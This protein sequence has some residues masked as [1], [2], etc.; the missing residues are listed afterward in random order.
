MEKGSDPLILPLLQVVQRLP[1]AG[2]VDHAR[3]E[4][5]GEKASVPYSA[6][7]PLLVIWFAAIF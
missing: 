4:L 5:F 2:E 3:L 7:R 1:G 6:D